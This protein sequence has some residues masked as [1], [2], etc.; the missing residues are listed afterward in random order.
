MAG[1]QADRAHSDRDTDIRRAAIQRPADSRGFGV[2][3]AGTGIRCS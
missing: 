2:R 3:A 1:A